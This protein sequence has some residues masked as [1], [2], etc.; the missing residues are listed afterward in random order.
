M[1]GL[2]EGRFSLSFPDVNCH[3]RGVVHRLGITTIRGDLDNMGRRP[4][5]RRVPDG[6]ITVSN[7]NVG[8]GA[9]LLGFRSDGLEA[10]I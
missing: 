8:R 7:D 1:Q 2:V 3:V 4:K 9:Q 10:R 5:L 6:S